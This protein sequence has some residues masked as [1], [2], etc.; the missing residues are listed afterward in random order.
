[1][2]AHSGWAALVSL[3]GPVE[4]AAVISRKRIITADAEFPGSK[5]PYHFVESMSLSEASAIV[6]RCWK[7][8]FELAV[9]ALA[10]EKAS[11][12]AKG[13][14]VRV[15][16]VLQGRRRELPELERILASHP[17]LHTAEGIFFRQV[18]LM[19]APACGMRAVE[20]AERGIEERVSMDLMKELG[21]GWGS[22][23]TLDQKYAAGAAWLGLS[24]K[25]ES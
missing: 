24:S 8:S 4:S 6:A 14:N 7:S 1:L 22:P 20:V 2:R 25:G 3:A 17:M 19:A 12:N 21:R 11:L 23:W 15:C 9:E 18:L 5:Q 13:F 16:A 10:S